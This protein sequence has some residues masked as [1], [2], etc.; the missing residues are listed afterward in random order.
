M[1]GFF[2]KGIAIFLGKKKK[3]VKN[4]DFQG[5]NK[6]LFPHVNNSGFVGEQMF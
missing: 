1:I 3:D 5:L 6:Q 2:Q 4:S